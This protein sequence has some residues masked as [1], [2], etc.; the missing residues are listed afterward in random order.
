MSSL[1]DLKKAIADAPK[2]LVQIDDRLHIFVGAD[3]AGKIEKTVK[4][5][6]ADGKTVI[7]NG[8]SQWIEFWPVRDHSKTG[9]DAYTWKKDGNSVRTERILFTKNPKN[10]V[11]QKSLG[12][13][14]KD[15][16]TVI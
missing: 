16:L 7:E 11:T 5:A 8:T 13:V 6:L 1:E 4:R 14:W 12:F 10:E 15:A 9:T 3:T 2:R